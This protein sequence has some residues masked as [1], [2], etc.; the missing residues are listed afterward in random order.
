ML[1]EKVLS[2]QLLIV[3]HYLF[4]LFVV[5]IVPTHILVSE[6]LLDC[7]YLDIREDFD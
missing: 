3:L 4:L 6:I 7:L 5:P 1:C 2:R